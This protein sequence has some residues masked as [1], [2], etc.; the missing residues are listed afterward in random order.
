LIIDC[1]IKGYDRKFN[2]KD[3]P[4]DHISDINYAFLDIILDQHGNYIPALSGSCLSVYIIIDP[5]ADTDKV[6]E[7]H[8]SVD[9]SNQFIGVNGNF[10]QFLLLKRQGHDFKFGL[11]VGGW[12]FSKNFSLAARTNEAS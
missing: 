6:Y 5:W 7:S 9:K 1:L 2:V 11:S 8:E 4:I 10:G 12:T 3:L